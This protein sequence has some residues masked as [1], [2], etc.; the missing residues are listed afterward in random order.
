MAL[1][2]AS[3]VQAK[4]DEIARKL[5]KAG[6]LKVGFLEGATY[7]DGT[8]VAEVAAYQEFGTP[9][10]RFP[11]PPRPFFR[12]MIAKESPGW[13]DAVLNLIKAYDY[14]TDRV[15]DAMGQLI[16]GQLQQSIIDT[17]SPPLSEVTL[18]LRSMQGSAGNPQINVSLRT[19]YEA[20]GKVKAGEQH[21]VSGTGAK[22]LV[23]TGQ[24]LGSVDY[25]VK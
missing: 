2:I 11:I 24:L 1:G 8:S 18:M 12:T 23:W 14:D 16:K 22:P 4:L 5:N 13:P 6:T 21:G 3:R 19:V 10:A 7:P 20:I 15:L 9:N 17:T 25:E